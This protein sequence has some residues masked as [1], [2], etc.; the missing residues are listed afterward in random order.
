MAL[1]FMVIMFNQAA[2]CVMAKFKHLLCVA[3]SLSLSLSHWVM[4]LPLVAKFRLG[5]AFFQFCDVLVIV[6][7]TIYPQFV[8]KQ[9]MKI[10]NI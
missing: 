9:N 2:H 1:L 6:H 3:L 7:K 5:S 4:A 10:K 8:Y